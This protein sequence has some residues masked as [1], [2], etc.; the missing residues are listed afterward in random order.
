MYCRII[1]SYELSSMK[2]DVQSSMSDAGKTL[3]SL[4]RDFDYQLRD[5]KSAIDS[6]IRANEDKVKDIQRNSGKSS[7]YSSYSSA[8]SSIRNAKQSID[9]QI[10]KIDGMFDKI[11]GIVSRL[12]SASSDADRKLESLITSYNDLQAK[13]SDTEKRL[14]TADK[15]TSELS[16]ARSDTDRKLKDL[17]GKLFDTEKRLA[18]AD[19]Q[20]SELSREKERIERKARNTEQRLQEEAQSAMR[21]A[22]ATIAAAAV[23]AAAN[24]QATSSDEDVEQRVSALKQSYESEIAQLR[25]VLS[26]KSDVSNGKTEPEAPLS[27]AEE[28]A[29]LWNVILEDDKIEVSEVSA[30]A[31]WLDRHPSE[32]PEFADLRSWCDMICARRE[33]LPE[34]AQALYDCSFRLLK[35]LGAKIAD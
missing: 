15:Q 24:Y 26:A 25:A 2:R 23:A 9:R 30:I 28:Y 10:S 32:S 11:S 5:L 19:K 35:S 8:D 4:K 13:L 17:K 6:L 3:S 21:R 33:V 12:V 1:S 16:R 29:R 20:T 18:T 31:K 34:D 22:N 27:P 14:A 7:G